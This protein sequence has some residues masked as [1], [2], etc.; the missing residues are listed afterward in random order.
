MESWQYFAAIFLIIHLPEG[1]F[2]FKLQAVICFPFG[3]QH[4]WAEDIKVAEQALE[5]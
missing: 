5:I 4:R 2:L 3:C 1:K